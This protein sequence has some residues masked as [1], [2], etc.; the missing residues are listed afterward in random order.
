MAVVR[1]RRRRPLFIFPVR[2]HAQ[3]GIL[4]HL[5]GTDLDLNG[6]AP[7]SQHDGVDRL[8]AVRLRVG[9]VV[10]ELIRKMT[11]VGM[12]NPQRGVAVLQALGDDTHRPHVKQ[13]VKG[14][15]LFLHFA[16]DAVDVL[17]S[18]IDFGLHPLALH[19]SAQVADKFI[20]VTFTIDP[21][22]VQQLGDALVLCRMQIAEAVVFQLPLQL[23]DTQPVRQ[24]GVDIGALF[25]R[26]YAF[27]FRGVFHLTQVSNALGELD[28]HAA[29]IIHHRQQHAADVINLFRGDGVGMRSLEL[30]D[31]G[32]IA[33]AIDQ[34]NNGLTHAFAQH[35]LAHHFGIRQREEQRGLQRIDVHTEHGED[36][37]HLD[38]APQQQLGV[39]V[40][41]S[42]LQAVCPG[43][44]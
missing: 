12:D 39:R 38:A 29:E 25:G 10:V 7:R 21:P 22:L 24:R 41:L 6:F 30:A 1:A 40:A 3:L 35:R 5:F 28:D 19:F 2:G 20:N 31:S 23:T 33:H 17:W 37:H 34:R 43:F 4:M 13:L 11:M 8:V 15:M 16:P 44:G 36:F 26:Q 14:E 9:H 18:A 27:V 32:H 42:M